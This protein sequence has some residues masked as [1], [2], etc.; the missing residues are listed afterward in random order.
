MLFRN[1]NNPIS[2]NPVIAMICG[3]L[4]K[5]GL[6]VIDAR[7]EA[8]VSKGEVC[9]LI[10]ADHTI[11]KLVPN[12]QG[13][14]FTSFVDTSIECGT[15]EELIARLNEFVKAYIAVLFIH[16]VLT[17]QDIEAIK[18]L[19]PYNKNGIRSVMDRKSDSIYVT[20]FDENNRLNNNLLQN[21]T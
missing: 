2:T 7:M 4:Q 10:E 3:N 17:P 13:T 8:D 15:E 16:A 9:N 21:K 5:F 19:E 1:K 12:T 14:A 6:H 18:N 20:I 11:I